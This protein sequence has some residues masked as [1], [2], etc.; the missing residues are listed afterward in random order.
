MFRET[1]A[2]GS[3]ML[4]V[5]PETKPLSF[6]MRNTPLS[7]DILFLDAAGTIVKMHANTTP[8]SEEPLPSE[9]PARFVLEVPGGFAARVGVRTGDRVLLGALADTPA[10]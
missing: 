1:L 2:E 6:W 3:G 4:F 7:L 10:S 8:Y 5:F 9:Q